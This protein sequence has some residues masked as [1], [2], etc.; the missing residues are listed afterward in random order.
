M[1]GADAAAL[2]EPDA[3]G[4]GLRTTASVGVDLVGEMVQFTQ[5]APSVKV[6]GSHEPF[7]S[8][9]VAADRSSRRSVSRGRGLVSVYWVPIVQGDDAVGV[10]TIGWNRK[11]PAPPERLERLMSL[12]AAE[13]GVAIER[14]ALLD[15]LERMAHTDDLTGLINRR[16]WDLELEREVGR[17][18]RNDDPLAVAMLDLDRFKA[19]N[20]ENGHQAGDALLKEAAVAWRTVLRATDVLARYGGEEFA[21]VLPRCDLE[22]ALVL[23]ARLRKSTPQEQTV[24]AGIAQ[25][26][27]GEDPV[28]LV[29]R[30]DAALYDAKN[31]G[32][33]RVIVAD[34][35]ESI[36]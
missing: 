30:A 35:T 3:S 18:R 31:S 15:R 27:P 34:P 11:V 16:A 4:T 28:A 14:A 13:A 2:L 23:L 9:D 7:F 22:D 32:R 17:A 29:A 36:A 19:Y 12:I 8:G 5:S 24:S 26:E 6:F 1:A 33:N 20:D 25:W 21:L 10:I